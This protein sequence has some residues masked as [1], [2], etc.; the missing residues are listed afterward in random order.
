VLLAFL[1]L[2]AACSGGGGDDS[3]IEGLITDV[4]VSSAGE[5]L[6]ISVRADD[7]AVHDF[8][9]ELDADALVDAAHLRQ[10]MQQRWPVSVAFRDSR[11]GRVAYRIDDAGAPPGG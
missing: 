7:G 9:V 8:A 3:P 2:L 1:G 4:R 6:G 10:H 11:D 5:L